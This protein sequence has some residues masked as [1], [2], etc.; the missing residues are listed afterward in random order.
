MTW[1][2]RYEHALMNVFGLPPRTFVSGDGCYLTDDQGR[3][4]LDLF[5][6]GAVVALGHANQ[7]VAQAIA[8]QARTLGQVSNLFA[9][10]PQ[11][12]LA[13]RLI[14]LLPTPGKV[15]FTNSGTEANEVALKITRLIGRHQVVAAEGSFHGRTLGSL[16]LT[17]TEKYRRPFEPLP[18]EVVFV[19]YGDV[20]ALKAA[21]DQRTAAVILEPFQGESGVVVPPDHYLAAAREV[22]AEHGALLWLD[23]IQS[24]LGRTGAWFAHTAN[25]VVPDLISLSKALGNGFPIGACLAL[26]PTADLL[27]VGSH[28][29][30]FGGNPLACRA[31]LATLP[32]I[33]ALLPQVTQIGDWLRTQLAALPGVTEVRGRG[34]AIGIRLNQPVAAAFRDAALKAGIILN[35]PRPDILRLVPPLII[36]QADL[37]PL[38]Q[39][40]PALHQ[41]ALQSTK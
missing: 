18:G 29:S 41:A 21:V 5:A 2:K 3:R 7:P 4:Y 6:G 31:S 26:G 39:S 32:Q 40:W 22:T 23:E 15:L 28:G 16:S 38:F 12:E 9:T 24:G 1:T 30:T 25:G 19:P 8:E 10:P 36:T 13:E 14:S 34:L 33:E 35:A 17:G 11:V 27:T 20:A 37:A